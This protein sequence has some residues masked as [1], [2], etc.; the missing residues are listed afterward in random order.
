MVQ[1]A[2]KLTNASVAAML[3][4]RGGRWVRTAVVGTDSRPVTLTLRL[5]D[6]PGHPVVVADSSQSHD[7]LSLLA[8]EWR[9]HSFA[10]VPMFLWPGGPA[11]LTVGGTRVGQL[12]FGDLAMLSVI[13]TNGASAAYRTPDDLAAA[14]RPLEHLAWHQLA[15]EGIVRGLEVGDTLARV[16]AEVESRYPGA[17]CSVLLADRAA[18]ALRHAAG[19]SLPEA[20]RE[21][22]DGLPMVDGAGVCGTA[23]A[24]GRPVIVEDTLADP[25]TKPFT[26]L[27]VE[28][29]LRSAWSYPLLD[30][31]GAVI[32][33]FALYRDHI[34]SPDAEE[35]AGVAAVAGIAALAIERARTEQ[36]LTD[37]AHRDPLTA[38]ANRAMFHDLLAYAL[39]AA[40]QTSTPCAVMF[41]DLDGF[42]V[43]N[44]S[45]G[46]NAGDRVL[47]EVA[48]RLEPVLPEGCLLAR[49][50]GDEF[51][52]LIEAANEERIAQVAD[53]V[54]VAFQDPFELDGGEFYVSTAIGVAMSS[55][56]RSDAGTLIR[57]ADAAMYAAKLRGRG[58]RAVF[59]SALRDQAIARMAIEGEL[60]RAVREDRLTVVYQPLLDIQTGTW[61]AAEALLRW[62]DKNFGSVPPSEFVP[63]AEEIGIV[64]QLG[65]NVLRRTMAQAKEWDELGIAV[66]LAVNVSP[67]QLTQPGIV[68]DVKAALE[69]TGVRPE[70][71]YVEV[72]ESAVM[73]DTD[74]A[75]EMLTEL[76]EMGVHCVIDDF[77]TGHS[78]IARLSELPVSAVKIDKS[79]LGS[80]GSESGATKIVAAIIE[81]AHA[82]DLLVT[83]EGVETAAALHVLRELGCDQ[84]QGYL[85]SRPIPP[86]A[87]ADL[88]KTAPD[89]P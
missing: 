45:L 18:G 43:I 10:T 82:F 64:G 84:A 23:A 75:K 19:P 52:V 29:G 76:G 22:I 59:D 35:M 1:H 55:E 9:M 50:G 42:K 60:R 46:H 49:F 21:A 83:A 87:I 73:T 13:A 53:R 62:P 67:I 51:T 38:L 17:R 2:F 44:D 15:L 4:M 25:R 54:E 79:F 78:S 30:A 27:V 8:Q 71:I 3:E 47:V 69:E 24:T 68:A 31:A 16:C 37:A 74:L 40:R 14:Q 61:C 66:P 20:F 89:L 80:L 32:G 65:S 85:F 41:L 11:L 63:I 39:N 81:L 36:A 7:A 70:L 72:T 48:T 5:D 28:H 33:T 77:G 6:V 86:A 58:Q 56:G 26:E 57:D 34:H 88:L 12:D